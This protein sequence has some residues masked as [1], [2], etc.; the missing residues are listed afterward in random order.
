MHRETNTLVMEFHPGPELGN[1][2]VSTKEVQGGFSAAMLDCICAHAVLC[3]SRLQYTV[4]AVSDHMFVQVAML[5]RYRSS[6]SLDVPGGFVVLGFCLCNTDL[7]TPLG[8]KFGTV[9]TLA[10]PCK[11]GPCD[12][13]VLGAT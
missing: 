11:A 7:P 9:H 8:C 12:R 2:K 4:R 5:N 3:L 1:G 10:T 13:G 6:V